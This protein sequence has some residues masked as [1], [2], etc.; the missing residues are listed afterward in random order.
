MRMSL[1]LNADIWRGLEDRSLFSIRRILHANAQKMPLAAL[2][3]GWTTR[4]DE[5]SRGKHDGY[6][7]KMIDDALENLSAALRHLSQ[8]PHVTFPMRASLLSDTVPDSILKLI[9][10]DNSSITVW[11]HADRHVRDKLIHLYS[12][13]F[14][15][16]GF[17]DLKGAQNAEQELSGL[18]EQ[19]ERRTRALFCDS[20]NALDPGWISSTSLSAAACTARIAVKRERHFH[21]VKDID[22]TLLKR[23]MAPSEVARQ[24]VEAKSKNN[25]ADASSSLSSSSSHHHR[26]PLLLQKS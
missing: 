13:C 21:A 9:S 2:S 5:V 19:S 6:T 10:G 1:I 17:F 14:D 7:G 22:P 12:T 23:S 18:L 8:S 25:V 4:I 3:L 20:E 11:G 26:R 15:G 16:R 24:V